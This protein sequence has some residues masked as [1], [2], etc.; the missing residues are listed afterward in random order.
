[1]AAKFVPIR[2]TK[3]Q[4]DNI[5]K[6]DGQA[7]YAYDIGRIYID[8]P[9]E[10]DPVD[11]VPIGGAGVAIFYGLTKYE[12]LEDDSSHAYKV[13]NY[14]DLETPGTPQVGDFIFASDG[15]ILRII[16]VYEDHCDIL[17]W[18]T[19]GS[20]GIATGYRPRL[21]NNTDKTTST[22]ISNNEPSV[23]VYLI[24]QAD[25]DENDVVVA[26]GNLRVDWWLADN[27]GNR[28]VEFATNQYRSVIDSTGQGVEVEFDITQYLLDRPN[29]RTVFYAK[30]I[31]TNEEPSFEDHLGGANNLNPE[32]PG[33]SEEVR[34][35]FT[36]TE[37][38]I[39]LQGTGSEAE[40]IQLDA[41]V[42]RTFDF[43]IYGDF[44]K[45]VRF[46]FGDVTEDGDYHETWTATNTTVGTGNTVSVTIEGRYLT[47]G[48]H[49]LI[50]TLLP[51]NSGASPAPCTVN[52]V[53]RDAQSEIPIIQSNIKKTTYYTYEVV[54][55][56]YSIWVPANTT[57]QIRQSI[58]GVLSYTA[59][60]TGTGG[61]TDTMH[62]R[63]TPEAL[64]TGT[65]YVDH[66]YQMTIITGNY[67]V[68]RRWDIRVQLDESRQ[69][70]KIYEGNLKLNFDPTGRANSESPATRN[71][72][73]NNVVGGW[74]NVTGSF[75]N[76]N[77]LDQGN[78]WAFD[79]QYT[80]NCLKITNGAEFTINGIPTIEFTPSNAWTFEVEFSV[81]NIKEYSNLITTI[82][83]YYWWKP[84]LNGNYADQVL[85]EATSEPEEGAEKLFGEAYINAYRISDA[86]TQEAPTGE[87]GKSLYQLFQESSYTNYELFLR[88]PEASGLNETQLD[89]L[90]YRTVDSS[91]NYDS[92]SFGLYQQSGSNSTVGFGT[93]GSDI[94]FS[95]GG[96]TVST[97][98]VPDELVSAS[99]VYDPT[100]KF[101]LVYINGVITGAKEVQATSFILDS[102]GK[103]TF[104]SNNCDL[105][106]YR[107]R[108]YNQTLS[109]QNLV[110]NY[111]VDRH[112]VTIYDQLSNMALW[113][114]GLGEYQL[115]LGNVLTYNIEHPA[116]P[117]I[118]YMIIEGD[119]LND[120]VNPNVL[121]YNKSVDIGAKVEFVNVPLDNLYTVNREKLGET[122]NKEKTLI[123]AAFGSGATYENLKE[124]EK[125]EIE[126]LFY[127]H[128]CPSFKTWLGN[129]NEYSELSVQGT[130]SQFYPRRNFKLKVD[131]ESLGNDNAD[132][133]MH[134]FMHKGPFEDSYNE[135][136][137][138][139]INERLDASKENT[140]KDLDTDCWLEDGWYF[141]NYTNTTD[142]WTLKVDYMESSGS[143]NAGYANMVGNC[144]PY[145]P[146]KTYIDSGAIEPPL[147]EEKDGKWEIDD[148]TAADFF[149]PVTLNKKH[150]FYNDT[151]ENPD[152]ASIIWKDFRTS[153]QGFPIMMFQRLND[154]ETAASWPGN[155][156]K[157]K[158]IGLY[159]MLID[160][161][162]DMIFGF[163]ADAKSEWSR[164]PKFDKIEGYD[165]DHPD[166]YEVTWEDNKKRKMKDITECWEFCDNQGTFCSFRDPKRRIELSFATYDD[167][168]N[169]EWADDREGTPLVMGSFEY[170]YNWAEDFLDVAFEDGYGGRA[171]AEELWTENGK[172]EGG[173]IKPVEGVI[174]EDK[175]EYKVEGF[176]EF[177]QEAYELGYSWALDPAEALSSA[178]NFGH[179]VLEVYQNWEKACAWVWS[180]NEEDVIQQN[181][182]EKIDNIY[183]A[184]WT[185]G[186]YYLYDI[187]S[188]TYVLD[189]SSSFDPDAVYY[190]STG[191]D[192]VTVKLAPESGDEIIYEQNKYYI[193]ERGEY[194][195]STEKEFNS[196]IDYYSPTILSN[197]VLETRANRIIKK[198][199]KILNDEDVVYCLVDKQARV[200]STGLLQNPPISKVDSY[201]TEILGSKLYENLYEPDTYYTHTGV[202]E[203]EADYTLSSAWQD[204]ETYYK[205]DEDK[206][207]GTI[208]FK[209][210]SV[211]NNANLVFDD[212]DIRYYHTV[213]S[214]S[215]DGGFLYDTKEYRRW[216][217]QNELSQH[218]NLDYMLTYFIMTEIF[219]CFDS[220]GKNCMMASWGPQ[221]ENGEFIWFPIFYDI[222]T[223][224]GINNT[225]IPSFEY[226]I[227]VTESNNFSTP[228]SILWNN[229][230]RDYFEEIKRR[231]RQL[232]G[233]ITL[234]DSHLQLTYN[235]QVAPLATPEWIENQYL[236]KEEVTGNIACSGVVPIMVKNMDMYFKYITPANPN[237]FSSN[238]I[239]YKHLLPVDSN[240]SYYAGPY[241]DRLF[242]LQGDR[243]FSRLDFITSRIDYIDSWMGVGQYARDS[244]SM[245]INAR[246]S[247]NFPSTGQ[248]GMFISDIWTTEDGSYW[249]TGDVNTNGK[250]RHAFDGEYWVDLT[251]FQ[252]SYVS[253]GTDNQ[254]L[255]TKKFDG[256]SDYVRMVATS[257]ESKIQTRVPVVQQLFYIY[258]I[259]NLINLGTIYNLYPQEFFFSQSGAAAKLLTLLLGWDGTGENGTTWYS[260]GLLKPPSLAGLTMLETLNLSNIEFS[261]DEG[262][263]SLT[264]DLS[265]S[266]KLQ[267]FRAVGSNINGLT[268][269]EGVSLSTLYVPKALQSLTLH[270]ANNLTKLIKT[271]TAQRP[272]G[273]NIHL[274]AEYQGLYIDGMFD[275]AGNSSD[276]I[277]IDISG[278][279]L[280][281]YSYEILDKLYQK[282]QTTH[283]RTSIVLEDLNWCPYIICTVGDEFNDSLNYY[284]ND[285]HFG[286]VPYEASD[287]DFNT[288]D[289]QMILNRDLYYLD[290]TLDTMSE[291]VPVTETTIEM[292]N[293]MRDARNNFVGVNNTGKPVISG[294]IYIK[295]TEPIDEVEL[296][297]LQQNVEESVN[298]PDLTIFAQNVTKAYSAEFL[299]Q[300]VDT[301]SEYDYVFV[302]GHIGFKSIQKISKTSGK[303][304]FDSPGF[305]DQPGLY[306][307][308]KT[309]YEFIGWATSPDAEPDSDEVIKTEE[310]WNQMTFADDWQQADDKETFT[311][312]AIF[313]IRSY[314]ITFHYN[315]DDYS[316]TIV[317]Y[318]Q[319]ENP[320]GVPNFEDVEPEKDASSLALNQ[321]YAFLGWRNNADP[322]YPLTD[323][324]TYMVRGPAEFWASFEQVSVYSDKNIHPEY[325]EVDSTTG[326][327]CTLKLIR[328]VKGKI[329]IPNTYMYNGQSY[330]VTRL[331]SSFASRVD[332]THPNSKGQNITHI[333]F[334][335]PANIVEFVSDNFLGDSSGNNK[336]QFIEFPDS[337]TRIGSNAFNWVPLYF[338]KAE[339]NKLP[340]SER[341][342]IDGKNVTFIGASAFQAAFSSN[343][344]PSEFV[345]GPNVTQM[346]EQAFIFLRPNIPINVRIGSMDAPSKWSVG[347]PQANSQAF[348]STLSSTS[349]NVTLYKGPETSPELTEARLQK[350]FRTN[351]LSVPVSVDIIET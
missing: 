189:S 286:L 343:W 206:D 279:G 304:W 41:D 33:S 183:E 159:R 283:S 31:G 193:Y 295:N 5:P 107:F 207:T 148:G 229:L 38:A 55:I 139:V 66:V 333:F 313:K 221:T 29:T 86:N 246:I 45:N 115:A 2:G 274:P 140:I 15:T 258:G 197:E 263:T 268:F 166:Q 327:G 191:T 210:V 76:F 202:G 298:Y 16:A 234:S 75:S 244:S 114:S 213:A 3:S 326:T 122:I 72:W 259:H 42:Q 187:N 12:D 338:D 80:S 285:K 248:A 63:I 214:A 241:T 303:T 164:G 150:I 28:L 190:K 236:F 106:L 192:Y 100:L 276:L 116:A 27:A 184:R 161:G 179:A 223:Q 74:N 296:F 175:E 44:E 242:A 243:Q 54:D 104:N 278:S 56:P 25:T 275:P 307:P 95:N 101:I 130:S 145:H 252:S 215:H 212:R 77:W 289:P 30:I 247:A 299:Y 11:R 256:T 152:E 143:Y 7:L 277:S 133:Y 336:L 39:D 176:N 330:Q 9:G 260:R 20:G 154:E 49:Q 323:L 132:K 251:P 57:Y 126:K 281:Y 121:P 14:T 13:Y 216:K 85:I 37:M 4:I 292:L 264:F 105:N 163:D 1:M 233:F 123:E 224:L 267:D 6:A 308:E 195:L 196:G 142:R 19:G 319:Y 146:L 350:L 65:T 120:V 325:Y 81:S 208:A 110:T 147:A 293:E 118:P 198:A 341:P 58:D 339:I 17:L 36:T 337:L 245:Y 238:N 318:V 217:F 270:Q 220:R 93:N 96:D 249:E 125:A 335:K 35:Y 237:I 317:K 228:D 342:V 314:P 231:Y 188:E 70:M 111:A 253:I 347:I 301:R 68:E 306:A 160:K 60:A 185:A 158:F 312:Y 200:N 177:K 321:T 83:R 271:A 109:L 284:R 67:S 218:F 282:Y 305:V 180:T 137:Q 300:P 310:E 156:Q 272:Q 61:F 78:G 151:I 230:Y 32:Y 53:A 136:N 21:K 90:E 155:S 290:D 82:T 108:I 149:S 26:G 182:Y 169:M 205:R 141:N 22:I 131:T 127:I 239:Y 219:E 291:D 211:T 94:F 328:Q 320:D 62:W 138:K 87:T 117:T 170:R 128:H 255:P 73:T 266:S 99:F 209:E 51:I 23:K 348:F 112:D 351:S 340:I 345:I 315:G 59:Q 171:D 10:N 165:P 316:Q 288:E 201:I 103:M 203:T 69:D 181:T 235:Q 102:N 18:S 240:G 24:A 232:R 273:T 324:S 157:V 34:V 322:S 168:G 334:Q 226:N 225:G 135:A 287:D 144:Y 124:E 254:A 88:D 262:A 178:E 79:E 47:H 250:K 346:G 265:D 167:D 71:S 329:T 302:N 349:Y 261:L 269:A 89:T 222:D 227:D 97:S 297:N 84:D 309:N 134:L 129:G 331:S 48:V 50:A 257:L 204:R 40:F 174:L 194:Y 294:T 98:I 113:V 186:T 92:I 46:S 52:I 119:K 43:V 172:F 162:S 280:N 344:H 173:D 332:S 311:F 199:N 8:I 91:F 153:M 64:P